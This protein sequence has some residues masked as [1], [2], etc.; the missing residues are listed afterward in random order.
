MSDGFSGLDAVVNVAGDA[1]DKRWTD[2]N[3][4]RFHESRVGVT[5]DIVHSL[6]Q[7]PEE[8]RP[9]ILVNASAVGYYGDQ[10]DSILTEASPQGEGYLAELCEE[11]EAAAVKGESLGVRVVLGRIG[12]VLGKDAASWKKMKPIFLMGGGGKLGSGKQYWPLVHLDD[13]AGGIVHALET[14]AIRGAMN[15]V[16][17]TTVKNQEFT[18]TLASVLKR[19]AVLPVPAFALKLAF[20]GF[21]EAL[22]ASHRVEA[23]VLKESGYQFEHPDLREL[24]ASL[25]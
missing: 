17:T 1:I 25:T 3:K 11:W 14:E 21:A 20:G 18:K 15:L 6:A 23:S 8:E 9:Q 2:E 12:V 16:G 7:L 4:K 10:G 19:P 5:S 22:L 24:L 13:V